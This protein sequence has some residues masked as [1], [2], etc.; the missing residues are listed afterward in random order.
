MLLRNNFRSSV[1]RTLMV[2]GVLLGASVASAQILEEVKVQGG[3]IEQQ[4]FD[5]PASVQVIDEATLRSS[6]PQ[7]NLSETLG[8]VPGVVS[9]NRNNYAQDV[10]ISIRG[11]GARAP[12][13]LRGI[14]LITDGI[15]A[16][17]PD[18][19]GQASTVSLTSASRIEVLTG[20]LAQ[21]YGNSSGGVI[22]TFTREAGATPEASTQIFAGSYGLTRTSFQASGRSG[23]VGIVAD[24]SNFGIEGYRLNSAA[25]RKQLNTVMTWDVKEDTKAR[26]ILN[27]FDMPYAKDPLGLTLAEFNRDASLAGSG[28]QTYSTRKAVAQNQLGTVVEHKV[29]KDLDL[30]ARV[31]A[32][33]RQNLQHQVTKPTGDAA[34]GAWTGLNRNFY[35]TGLQAKG[36][37]SFAD[38]SGIDWV[39]GMDY[40]SSKELRRGGSTLNGLQTAASNDDRNELNKAVN[41]DFFAQLNWH[42]DEKWTFTTGVRNSK[43]ILSSKDNMFTSALTDGSGEVTYKATSPVFGLTFHANDA[44]NLYVNMGNGFETPTLSESAYSTASNGTSINDTFNKNLLASKSHHQEAGLKWKP[45]SATQLDAAIFH[46]TTDNEI[47][48]QVSASGKTSF[49]NASKTNRDGLEF[50]FRRAINPHWRTQV[51]LTFMSV[52]YDQSFIYRSRGA[53]LTVKTGNALPAIPQRQFF[54]N[55]TWTQ[56]EQSSKPGSFTP[57]MELAVDLVG[58]SKIFADDLNTSQASGFSMVNIRAQQK[59]KWGPFNTTTYAGID[60]LFER[61]A[62]GSVI[63][64]Q[65]NSQFFEPAMPLTALVGIQ[66]TMPF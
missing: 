59:Y 56:N 33:D 30:M 61:K 55:L 63:V 60:N 47:T 13:G 16:T 62:A 14:R 2:S 4:Q 10:Q 46:I 8:R 36:K 65:A 28:A 50:A 39:L 31:Y 27:S 52:T 40:D 15:P 49:R 1:T 21:L 5:T 24:Y 45:D 23:S 64:N 44:L 6:G 11:F 54:G 26:F 19:Q 48:T 17:I 12:F 34:F 32:G 37:R 7:V 29:D 66:A 57:G 20:P 41:R 18:G 38:G 25:Q 42:F 53:N 35:G 51:A 43:I 22:Q 3:R 58:R 9:L